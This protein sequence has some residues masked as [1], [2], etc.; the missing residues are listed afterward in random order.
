MK[1]SLADPEIQLEATSTVSA[2]QQ[3]PALR[4]YSGRRD[5]KQKIL[6]CITWFT[7]SKMHTLNMQSRSKL[8]FEF[9]K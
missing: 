8:L 6:S 1:C 3:S 5:C 2:L 4:S 7:V 9:D